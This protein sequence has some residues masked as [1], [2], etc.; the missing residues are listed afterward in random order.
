MSQNIEYYRIRDFGQKF[1]AAIEYLRQHFLSLFV[2]IL[3]VT[4][5]FTVLGGIIQYTNFSAL[6]SIAFDGDT[7]PFEILSIMGEMIPLV[8][9]TSLIS[10]F[11]N[12]AMIGSIF[13]Y[14][15]LTDNN[16]SEVKPMDVVGKLIPKLG[17]IVVI[18]IASSFIV[19]IAFFLFLIP[20]IY[21][22]VVLSL[23]V[24]IY[25]FEDST[26]GEA[27]SKPFTLINGKWWSTFGLLF[28]TIMLVFILTFAIAF[29]IGLIIGLREL[30]TI[31]EFIT[32]ESVRFWEI[33]SGSVINSLSYVF[34]SLPSI[35]LAFQY[36]NLTERI[37]GRG[38]KSEIEGFEDIK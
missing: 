31:E 20:G 38:L 17:G 15:R 12:A 16:E 35:A 10:L 1:N 14:M 22:A 37:E 36:F 13:M 7:D 11:L 3:V 5:P 8:M 23:A 19:V 30:F 32:D 27:L 4:I 34:F 21:M 33:L 6:Q 2:V 25:V 24:P 28:V 9:L 18:T 29:P 26:V